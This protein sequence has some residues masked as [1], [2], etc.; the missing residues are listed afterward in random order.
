MA[1]SPA[2][3]GRR[4]AGRRTVMRGAAWTAPALMIAAP[5]PAFAAS[6]GPSP[7][8]MN[9]STRTGSDGTTLT[10]AS[11]FTGTSAGS[12]NLST[13]DQNVGWVKMSNVNVDSTRFNP[14]EY[15]DLTFTFSRSVS[16]LQFTI[17][18]LDTS[19][20]GWVRQFWDRVALLNSPT[21]TSANDAGIGGTGTL[22]DPWRETP[23]SGTSV[24]NTA[25]TNETVVS[26][27]GPV[28]SFT[29]RFWTSEGDSSGVHSIW[30]GAMTYKVPC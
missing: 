28:S 26:I 30:I 2:A 4:A 25:T 20:V 1:T 7:Q 27:A 22:T 13:S 9:L 12:N 16:D 8:T 19:E 14:A 10:L 6:C 23:F 21:F 5:I 15:Q 24:A 11:S 18:D 29:I 3:T 17:R